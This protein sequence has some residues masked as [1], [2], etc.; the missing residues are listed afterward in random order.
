LQVVGSLGGAGGLQGH[1][2]PREPVAI[3]MFDH[4]VTHR[5]RSW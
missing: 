1:Q 4:L 5:K 2:K 3:E